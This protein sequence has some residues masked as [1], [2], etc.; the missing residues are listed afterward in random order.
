MSRSPFS[1][2]V[3]TL[4][5]WAANSLTFFGLRQ[6]TFEPLEGSPERLEVGNMGS[7]SDSVV[8]DPLGA[9]LRISVLVFDHPLSVNGS[10]LRIG[11]VGSLVAG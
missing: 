7:D 1:I 3:A 6:R 4:F 11:A 10:F 5:A 2:I 8:S 9:F